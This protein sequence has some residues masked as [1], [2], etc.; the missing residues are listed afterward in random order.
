MTASESHNP[1][2]PPKECYPAEPPR[3]KTKT[4]PW[5]EIVV[6]LA[7]LFLLAGMFASTRTFGDHDS[8]PANEQVQE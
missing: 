1:Y 7:I 4:L 2:Q 5:T 6:V 3:G 8:S